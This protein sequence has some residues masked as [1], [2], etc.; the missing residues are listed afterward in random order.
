MY[1]NKGTVFVIH[2]GNKLK[3]TIETS[4][5][6]NAA[7]SMLSASIL[8][9]GDTVLNNVPLTSD[10]IATLQILKEL[11]VTVEVLNGNKLKINS[12]SITACDIS[13]ELTKKTRASILLLGALLAK[14][15][16]ICI[17]LPGGDAIGERPLDL[18]LKGLKALGADLTYGK[19]QIY[20]QA[21]ELH[22]AYIFLDYP[23]STATEILLIAATFAKGTTIIDNAETKPEIVDLARYLVKAG[24]QISGA[25]TSMIKIKGVDKLVGPTYTVIPDY[26]EAGTFLIASAITEGDLL[27][28]G[29]V[30][31]H[32]RPIVAKLQESGVKI[33]KFSSSIRL[34]A[35]E[36]PKGF[37]FV[38]TKPF[39]G[40]YSD[41]QPLLVSLLA[42]A[43]GTSI[44]KDLVFE[45]RFCYISEL[46]K[47]GAEI[48]LNESGAV[49]SGVKRLNGSPVT[50]S[51]I[52]GGAALILAGLAAE[53]E[54]RVVGGQHI[55]RAY[56]GIEKK[57]IAVGAKIEK[58]TF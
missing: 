18:H 6:K 21:K 16:R 46:Q 48:K 40:L 13:E 43:D 14:G 11:N 41:L 56:E 3:G 7:L 42:K 24:A 30:S 23:S 15:R 37:N 44:V 55:E 17:G 54:T 4:G 38:A 5:S 27:V 31:D 47:M 52:R 10:I 8:F 1:S 35:P 2:G 45:K 49:I 12:N 25:G 34:D 53:G 51:D 50:A 58:E 39:P 19:N 28:K 26:L 36:R 20:A 57:L 33:N 22:G 32:L 9:C 29:A